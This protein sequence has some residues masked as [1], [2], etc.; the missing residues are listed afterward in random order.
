MIK[1][2]K[3]SIFVDK[4]PMFP[5]PSAWRGKRQDFLQCD[6]AQSVEMRFFLIAPRALMLIACARIK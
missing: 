2:G 3:V 1:L 5:Q 6:P 4:R